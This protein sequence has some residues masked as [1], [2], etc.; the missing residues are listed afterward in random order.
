MSKP[1]SDQKALHY[2]ADGT[3]IGYESYNAGDPN[4]AGTG[5]LVPL[6][7][8]A[9]TDGIY[10]G[11]SANGYTLEMGNGHEALFLDDSV[12]PGYDGGARL[13]NIDTIKLG[14]TGDQLIDLTSPSYALNVKTIIGGTG[15]E[16]ILNNSGN[17]TI[18]TGSGD[19]YVWTGSGDN[20]IIGGHGTNTYVL[21]NGND[22]VHGG[23]GF[24][25]IDFSHVNGTLTIDLGDHS[26]IVTD[27][28][29][30]AV[31]ANDS[32]YSVEKVVGNNS[33]MYIDM[34]SHAGLQAVGG[35][36]NDR[37]HLEGT[38][39][40][41]T[42][43]GGDN[44]YE[45]TRKFVAAQVAAGGATEITDFT[46]GQDSLNLS[47]FLKGQGIRHAQY[48]DVVQLH[49]TAKGTMV[50]VL[51]GGKWHDIAMLDSVHSVSVAE[52]A[53]HDVP[54]LG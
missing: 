28:T 7:G 9:Q 10:V 5:N 15:N 14:A 39:D 48:S 18:H 40:V 27:P 53:H 37:F 11:T 22:V 16:I 54:L 47:D 43:G 21:G 26:A 38:S 8:Y 1:A 2:S 46:V 51:A 23:S 29:T 33:G 6:A 42:G 19:D 12:S 4:G 35:T 17:T 50:D 32:L 13:V 36:G 25:T 41:L 34:G 3:W 24:D 49:D 44:S 30:G 31:L 20:T 45:W 52:L